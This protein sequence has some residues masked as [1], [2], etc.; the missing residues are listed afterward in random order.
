MKNLIQIRYEIYASFLL[1]NK[2]HLLG[3]EIKM[4]DD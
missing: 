3:E 2:N 4:I 1:F